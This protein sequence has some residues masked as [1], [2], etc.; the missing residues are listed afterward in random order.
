[1]PQHDYVIAD[2]DGATFLADLNDMTAAAVSNNSGA[3]APATTYAY[4]F[5]A[6]TANDLLKQRNAAN[7]AWIDICKLSTWAL[8][9]VQKLTATLG[10][11]GGTATAITATQAPAT[12][13]AKV[14]DLVITSGNSGAATTLAVN[15][16]AAKSVKAYNSSGSKVDTTLVAGQQCRFVDD[17]TNWVLANP[18]PAASGSYLTGQVVQVVSVTK[19]DTF[20]T[21]STS[22]VD[23]T[24]L[25]AAITPR[26]SSNKI[27]AIM[28]IAL[29]GQSTVSASAQL[30]RGSTPIGI[31]DAAGSRTRSTITV[32]GNASYVSG[33][34]AANVLDSPATASSVT[35]KVQAMTGQGGTTAYVNRS[36][37]DA[38]NADN[39]RGIS[40][41]T[42]LE[43][44][45]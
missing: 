44:D 32:T 24:G 25:S 1:M 2:A 12:S 29:N 4:M 42:L 41:L 6:D 39:G 22:M 35:Y 26:K 18:L 30:V 36:Q 23:V 37:N 9:S 17:G 21:S 14:V 11:V 16:D 31:G 27:L 15:G 10:T 43:I 3:S 33:S 5:W 28:S 19:T 8:P 20:S 7:S 34:A 38:D 45:A 40:T 13:G